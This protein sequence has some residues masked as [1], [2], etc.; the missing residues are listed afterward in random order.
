MENRGRPERIIQWFSKVSEWV[1]RAAV[2]GVMVVTCTNS[3]LRLFG[4]PIPG[5]FDII[6]LLGAMAVAFAVPYC[7]MQAGHTTVELLVSRLPKRIQAAIDLFTGS[8]SI[9]FFLFVCWQLFVY[10]TIMHKSGEISHTARIPYFPFLYLASLMFLF[11][12]LVLALNLRKS[13]KRLVSK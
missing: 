13:L 4:Y 3:I 10:A 12:C 9:V 2:I 1:A 11:F 5:G 7:A 8:L 6:M